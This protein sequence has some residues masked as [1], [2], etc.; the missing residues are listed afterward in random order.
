MIARARWPS[1]DSPPT[2][3]GWSAAPP[4]VIRAA[5]PESVVITST[6]FG[7]GQKH[8]KAARPGPAI[9]PATSAADHGTPCLSAG[10]LNVIAGTATGPPG[11][12]VTCTLSCCPSCSAYGPGRRLRRV[13]VAGWAPVDA[14]ATC[15]GNP[16]GPPAVLG[17]TR[18]TATVFGGTAS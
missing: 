6:A 13:S 16:S 14:N 3:G 5:G 11:V 2:A 7:R 9:A 1:G 15:G 18:R 10:R 8:G 4:S 17:S 12:S